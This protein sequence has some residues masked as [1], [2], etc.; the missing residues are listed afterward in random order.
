ML[1]NFDEL[2]VLLTVR[3]LREVLQVSR[4]KA[5]EL[6]RDPG[7]RVVRIGRAVRI[8]KSGLKTWIEKNS[9]NSQ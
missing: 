9:Q 7:L 3:E 1:R 4:A 5:Y 6:I 8:P 2:P